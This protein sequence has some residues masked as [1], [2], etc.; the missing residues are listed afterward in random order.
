MALIPVIDPSPGSI[1]FKYPN[2]S[3]P[4]EPVT[5]SISPNIGVGEYKFMLSAFDNDLQGGADF[6]GFGD[7][8]GSVLVGELHLVMLFLKDVSVL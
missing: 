6:D 1:V 4:R 5:R 3:T 2:A 8:M 7:I